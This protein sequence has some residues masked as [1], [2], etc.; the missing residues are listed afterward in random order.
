MRAAD[1]LLP[2]FFL[3]LKDYQR[4]PNKQSQEHLRT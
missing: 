3:Y 1:K 2:S 4:H